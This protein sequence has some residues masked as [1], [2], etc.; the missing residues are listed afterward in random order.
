MNDFEVFKITLK[1]NLDLINMLD[2][3]NNK[4]KDE[5]MLLVLT[6][7]RNLLNKVIPIYEEIN[8]SA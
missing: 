3:E 5:V 7:L 2:K 1:G 6:E 4:K 8:K